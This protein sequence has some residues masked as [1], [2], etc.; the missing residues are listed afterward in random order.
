MTRR[1]MLTAEQ[2]KFCAF[3]PPKFYIFVREGIHRS[4]GTPV[5]GGCLSRVGLPGTGCGGAKS[6]TGSVE[7][8]GGSI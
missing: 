8:R 1:N 3:L 5:Y 2:S 4:P 7:Q 6:T